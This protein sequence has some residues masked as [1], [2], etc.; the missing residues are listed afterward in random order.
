MNGAR[1][2]QNKLWLRH[3]HTSLV[4][5][6]EQGPEKNYTQQTFSSPFGPQASRLINNW[7]GANTDF[8]AKYHKIGLKWV[9]KWRAL[10]KWHKRLEV[11][12]LLNAQHHSLNWSG[13]RGRF[14]V[15]IC[16]AG[17]HFNKSAE[18]RIIRLEW[19]GVRWRRSVWQNNWHFI[20]TIACDELLAIASTF[21]ERL[22]SSNT[23][24]KHKCGKMILNILHLIFIDIFACS[25]LTPDA[26]ILAH[27]HLVLYIAY[28]QYIQQAAAW[29]KIRR[30]IVLSL[31]E[32]AISVLCVSI[33]LISTRD[34]TYGFA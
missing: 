5:R 27:A 16:S 32:F 12:R 25:A 23:F 17:N 7:L 6:Q 30:R 28:T 29:K 26:I 34:V 11:L 20:P 1:S 15:D 21:F 13:V 31:I 2:G 24:A 14:F 19:E 8:G 3:L 33:I 22:K 9:I 18:N 10:I 4:C